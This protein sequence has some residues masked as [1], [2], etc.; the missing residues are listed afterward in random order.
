[1]ARP[2]WQALLAYLVTICIM[3]LCSGAP[4]AL[5]VRVVIRT[6]W[7]QS[8]AGVRLGFPPRLITAI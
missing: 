1:M 6:S 4:E 8:T 7:A 2:Y 3:L 5:W